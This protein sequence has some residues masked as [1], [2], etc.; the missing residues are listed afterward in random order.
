[1]KRMLFNA[2]H[3]EELRVAIV[4]G[5]TLVDLDI[6]FI[7]NE[8]KRNNIYKGIVTKVEPSLEAVFVDYGASRQGFLSL[9]D[10]SRSYFSDDYDPAAPMSQV[11]VQDVISVGDQMIVQVE[12]N[13]RGNK[14]AALTTFISLA[15]R[16]LVLL[17]HNPRGG[18]ISRQIEGS[19]RY[20][21]RENISQLEVPPEHAVI[22][23]TAG[24]GQSVEGFHADLAYLLNLWKSIE[25]AAEQ[26][27]KPFL[28]YQ[29]S[30]LVLRTLRDYMR[31][32]VSHILSDDKDLYEKIVK[33]VQ[34][35]MPSSKVKIEYYDDP[36]PLFSRYQIE[37]QIKDAFERHVQLPTGGEIVIEQTEALVTIDVNS[38][39]S[40]KGA[41]IEETA[42][43]TN[44]EAVE[45]I[46]KQMR[47]RDIGGLIVIDLIDMT[48]PRNRRSVENRFSE[49]VESDRA[50]TRIGRISQFGLLEMSRQRLRSSI[51]ESSHDT[52][53][54]CKGR[55]FIRSVTSTG[56][57]ILRIIEE[58]ALKENTELIHAHLPVDVA[59]FL[60]NEKRHELSVI[61]RR[62][63]TRIVVVPSRTMYTPDFKIMRFTSTELENLG[64]QVSY[65]LKS[66]DQGS[67]VYNF[68]RSGATDKPAAVTEPESATYTPSTVSKD[69]GSST[70]HP[71]NGQAPSLLKRVVKS[72]FASSDGTD[73]IDTK[74]GR[75]DKAKQKK[76]ESGKANAVTSKRSSS[77]G[78]GNARS[79][80]RNQP[81]RRRGPKS[82]ASGTRRRRAGTEVKS[83][84]VKPRAAAPA[85]VDGN[86]NPVR[87]ASS[88]DSAQ[89]SSS[90]GNRRRRPSRAS[91]SSA[92]KPRRQKSETTDSESS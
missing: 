13:E 70:T 55:G 53:P 75:K 66:P 47:V 42:L 17:P 3:S 29:E 65:T 91:N 25:S 54:R 21:L 15:G 11:R 68:I 31:D 27:S 44:L 7:D 22:G 64:A 35:V 1:M 84:N 86:K 24:I 10:I 39:R 45:H 8:S 52:C 62:L 87:Q 76:N 41:D 6:E 79:S 90:S 5:Q 9:K 69:R 63:G 73:A 72:I 18:G 37:H 20:E 60:I 80:N 50:R 58:D 71:S 74:D 82:T 2:T 33:F 28:I 32:D 56:L 43:E 67:E 78:R 38:A 14:G 12:R 83:G 36:I 57:S 92:Q 61:E 30:S 40:T 88:A 16:Y 26:N 4:D 46:A 85:N 34:D 59:T 77:T 48:K 49:A 89:K 19:E 51:E 81:N 23:R